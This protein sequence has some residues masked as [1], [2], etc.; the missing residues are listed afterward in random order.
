VG[1]SRNR[2]ARVRGAD[3]IVIA[4]EPGPRLAESGLARVT[5]RTHARVAARRAVRFGRIRAR[6][7]RGT[8]CP[9]I[10]ALVARRTRDRVVAD[11]NAGRTGVG[12]RA[13]VAVD[14]RRTV[15][16]GR[17]RT[18]PGRGVAG[19]GIVARVARRTRDG[20]AADASA[21][22]TGVALGAGVPVVATGSIGRGHIGTRPG[23][24]IA[25][26]DVTGIAR[27]AGHRVRADACAGLTGVRLGARVPVG[28][29]RAVRLGGV[30]AD[31]GRG[32]AGPGIVALVARGTR[33]RVRADASTGLTG[34]GLGTRV[35]VGAGRAVRLGRIRADSGRGIA[36]SGVVA[37]V[38]R[39]TGDGVAADA[40][41]GLTR[42][43]LG[44]RVAVGA[45]RAVGLRRIR[46]GPGRCVAC[47]DI[48]ALVARGT[49]DRIAAD[50][51]A[52]L[53]RV[54]LGA[55]VAVG[56]RRAVRLG[57]IRAGAG[58]SVA[59]PGVV[60]LVA[61][62]ARDRVAA[63]ASAGLAAVGLRA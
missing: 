29:R 60:A 16:L 2:I 50:A 46:A 37:L 52:G 44:A 56:A 40:G 49:R 25:G 55:R 11:A 17:I 28:A 59:R 13:R 30:R 45:G 48:V 58:R 41:A 53:T 18:A 47:P 43:G 10:V 51:G 3:V 39:R 1:A 12:L 5:D 33:H 61:R 63:D 8:A 7:G 21:R 27:R 14:A 36:R 4:V 35:A 20:V 54:G 6:P 42:V 62:R 15:R 34:V 26:G 24:R 19:P 31:P 38:A 32:I 57:R 23:P 22:Q 9:G